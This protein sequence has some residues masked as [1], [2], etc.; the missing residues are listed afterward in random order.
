[1]ADTPK[2]HPALTI[3]NVKSL[4]PI[5]LDANQ[6]L[7]HSWA[8]LFKVLCR[9]HDLTA[10]IVPPTEAAELEAYEKSKKADM[11]FWRRLDAAVL[12]WIYSSISSD[13]LTAIL[14]KDDTAQGAWTRLE[15]MFQDN[16]ASRASHLEQELA[17]LDFENFSSIDGYCN[18]I[19][20]LADRLADVDAPILDT[21]LI[22]KLTAGLPEAYAGTIDFIQNQ[23]PLPSFESCR[24]RLKLA[25]RAIKNRLAKEGGTTSRSPTAL[26]SGQHHSATSANSSRSNKKSNHSK[27]FDSK[28]ANKPRN[29]GPAQQQQSGPM[30]QW[31]FQQAPWLAQWAPYWANPP[32]P[33]PAQSWAPRPASSSTGSRPGGP[34][35]LGHA[36]QAYHATD[37]GPNPTPTHIEAALQMLANINRPDTNYYM[38][39]GATS[40]MTADQDGSP[41]NEM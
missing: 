16:K 13:L 14:L 3:T 33:Y 28:P 39:T 29:S 36:P 4:I 15:S 8:A 24:S 35:I 17:D 6:G 26:V 2:Y 23:E 12:N 21:R 19:K 20:S 5:T 40:H 41:P 1:M 18:H 31:Q 7:Y 9:V 22:L 30:R 27:N 34:G 25:E 32:C 10:H 37:N 38:D 11:A